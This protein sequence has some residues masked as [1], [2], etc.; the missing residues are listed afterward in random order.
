VHE[1][2]NGVFGYVD[3]NRVVEVFRGPGYL[4]GLAFDKEIACIGLS[5]PRETASPGAL[6]FASKLAERGTEAAC[7]VVFVDLKRGTV[8]HS[9]KFGA[10]VDEIYDI[11]VLN[12]CN[13][14][15]MSPDSPEASRTYLLGKALPGRRAKAP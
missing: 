12:F 6:S 9:L 13:P 4:R 3:G 10:G 5:R 7:G 8:L 11:A 1:S 2:G 15:L 14:L